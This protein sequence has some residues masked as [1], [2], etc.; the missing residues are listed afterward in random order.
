MDQDVFH[1]YSEKHLDKHKTDVCF[2]SDIYDTPRLKRKLKKD[3]IIVL[4]RCPFS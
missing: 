1:F 3:E 2:V 4:F